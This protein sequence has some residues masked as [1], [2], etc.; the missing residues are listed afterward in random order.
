MVVSMQW[1]CY[2]PVWQQLLILNSQNV[3]CISYLR[4]HSD[5]GLSTEKA[6][7][8][9]AACCLYLGSCAISGDS[10]QVCVVKW[11]SVF[12]EATWY[13]AHYCSTKGQSLQITWLVKKLGLISVITVQRE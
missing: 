2:L 1:L 3:S 9:L 7:V 10:T 13:A 6:D 5:L 8:C 12:Q 11:Q 4:V